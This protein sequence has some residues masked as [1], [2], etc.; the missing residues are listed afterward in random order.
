MNN[1]NLALFCRRSKHASA[2]STALPLIA[3]QQQSDLEVL[4]LM[5]TDQRSS[6]LLEI[7]VM[8]AATSSM[9]TCR[10]LVLVP[11]YPNTVFSHRSTLLLALTQQ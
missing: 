5:S 3:D 7:E 8:D 10:P 6:R 9:A 1:I 2:A 11:H 4:T